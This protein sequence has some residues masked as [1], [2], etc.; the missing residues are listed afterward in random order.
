MLS[1][2]GKTFASVGDYGV[3]RQWDRETGRLLWNQ[4]GHP[5]DGFAAAYSPDGTRLATS[6]NDAT[7]RLWDTATGIQR[8]VI[9]TKKGRSLTFSP[10]GEDLI[11]G[12]ADGT[13]DR[14]RAGVAKSAEDAPA[15]PV[16][17]S[18]A[19]AVQEK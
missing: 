16:Q 13:T 8:L 5:A 10:D 3:V 1:P 11:V 17:K 2:D 12:Y 9:R 15:A 19:A 18:E 4:P 7:I 14:L 6:G